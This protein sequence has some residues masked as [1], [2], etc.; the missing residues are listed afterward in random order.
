[1]NALRWLAEPTLGRWQ[2]VV[3]RHVGWLNF[4]SIEI[5]VHDSRIVEIVTT[6]RIRFPH[7]G[8][9]IASKPEPLDGS[10]G[11]QS[12]SQVKIHPR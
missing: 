2:D 7:G 6:E 11:T 3:H 12:G 1:M 10:P 4:G 5:V 9:A 8:Q